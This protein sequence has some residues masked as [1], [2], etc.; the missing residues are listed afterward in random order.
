MQAAAPTGPWD[1]QRAVD[2]ALEHNLTV[3]QNQ[4]TAETNNA[5]LRQSK[6]AQLPTANL[7]GTQTWNYGRSVNPLTYEFQN[8]TTRSNNFS[9]IAQVVLFQGF[10][11]RNTVK[12]NTLDYQASLGDI[13]KARNDLSLNVASQFLQLVLSEELVRTNQLK[14]DSD[15]QQVERTRKLLKAGSVAESNLLDLQ[16]QQATDELNVITAQNQRDIARLQLTQLLNLDAAGQ[17]AF[18]I[19]VPNLPDPD[20]QAQL[21]EDP[22]VTYQTA[23]AT[24]PD[25]KAADLR[26]RSAQST[27]DIA[28]GGYMPRLSFGASIFSGY[29]SARTVTSQ[30]N[31]STARKTT[32]FVENPTAPGTT[33]PL[34]VLVYQRNTTILS[35]G[36][37]EQL[38]QNLGRQLQFALSIPILNG[39]Q[40]RTNVQR[41]IINVQQAQLNAEQTRLTLRQNIQ[42]AYADAVAAQRKFSAARRQVEAQTTSYRNAEIRFNNGLLN[43]TEF[44]IT[45]NNLTAAESTM[46]QAK[47]EYIFRR[48]VLDFYQGK[49]LTL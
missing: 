49:P 39:L 24:Q 17:A 13:E 48:K 20:E 10:Q 41:S 43:G 38:D 44:N 42:Q 27:V 25:I 36:Y 23:L 40:V 2:Y 3:R 32:F 35:Q 28:R 18:Q 11:L 46:I 19:Q 16:A 37:W 29:S 6:A 12:R 26:V 4:L 33:T 7:N 30:G 14:V 15:V 22:N 21:N 5:I 47:Y 34:N 45:K 31:D 9:G 8:Q 1:L